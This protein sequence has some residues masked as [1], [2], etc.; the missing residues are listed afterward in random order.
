MTATVDSTEVALT[1]SEQERRDRAHARITRIGP[2]LDIAALSWITPILRLFY[3]DTWQNQRG[4]L[5]RTL[6]L[7]V[8]A[9]VGF[10]ALASATPSIPTI[11]IA[12]GVHMPMMLVAVV[13][14]MFGGYADAAGYDADADADDDGDY[15][16]DDVDV[17][18]EV[19]GCCDYAVY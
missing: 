14:K 6:F 15:V 10:I 8:M 18:A 11:E 16:D 2:F 7:P 3:G 1:Q 9:F 12:K 13:M 19:Y 5:M 17:Y 4:E